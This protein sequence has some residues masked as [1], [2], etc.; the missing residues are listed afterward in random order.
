MANFEEAISILLTGS[1]RDSKIVGKELRKFSDQLP[2]LGVLR[3]LP[4][5]EISSI[6]GAVRNNDSNFVIA[7]LGTLYGKQ[8]EELVLELSILYEHLLKIRALSMVN[9]S[10]EF[11]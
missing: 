8:L 6:T 1:S 3:G 2:L 5:S 9:L 7:R 4:I 10:E 11:E